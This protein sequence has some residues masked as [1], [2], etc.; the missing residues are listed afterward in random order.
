MLT[1]PSKSPNEDA[2]TP[3]PAGMIKIEGGVFRIGSDRHYPEEAPAH[4]VKVDGFAGIVHHT[5]AEREYTY[6]RQSQSRIGKLDKAI[7]EAVAK[8]WTVVDMKQD[9]KTIFR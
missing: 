4:T 5:D 3:S 7:D 6:D 8:K 1:R 2:G 9:W